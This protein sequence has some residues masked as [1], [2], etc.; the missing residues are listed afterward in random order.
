[1]SS[2]LPEFIGTAL[3]ILFGNGVN[4]NVTLTKPYGN[5]GGW[6]VI[7]FGWAIAVFLGVYVCASLGAC[8]RGRR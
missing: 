3:L 6:I 4:A 5:S 8:R 7:A 1:M 2:F